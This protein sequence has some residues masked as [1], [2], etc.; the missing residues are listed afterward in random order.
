MKNRKMNN[1]RLNKL[2]ISK[3]LDVIVIQG[4]KAPIEISERRTNCEYCP[5]QK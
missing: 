1:L 3:T 5:A 2:A 4:G